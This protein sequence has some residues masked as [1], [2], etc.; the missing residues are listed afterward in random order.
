MFFIIRQLTIHK[1]GNLKQVGWNHQ[2]IK[3]PQIKFQVRWLESIGF[4]VG[5]KIELT[6]NQSENPW[7]LDRGMN[8]VMS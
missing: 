3:I 2:Y 1:I 6:K 7:S 5:K 4:T 8:D